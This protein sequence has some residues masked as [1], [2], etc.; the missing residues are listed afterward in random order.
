MFTGSNPVCDTMMMPDID[1]NEM[2]TPDFPPNP[3]LQAYL[4][5]MC[6]RLG[7]EKFEHWQKTGDVL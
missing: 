6:D 7:Q 4:Q 1:I 5:E 3:Y 2:Q